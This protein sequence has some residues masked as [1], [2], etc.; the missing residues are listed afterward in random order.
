MGVV[1]A[2]IQAG[3]DLNQAKDDGATPLY[4]ACGK[5]HLEVVHALIQAGADLNQAMNNAKGYYT[6]LSIAHKGGYVEVVKLL[7]AAG[8]L[9][10]I[11]E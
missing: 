11:S 8:A 7:E 3:A 9:S 2:L 4:V 10:V 6:P 1:H 5:G